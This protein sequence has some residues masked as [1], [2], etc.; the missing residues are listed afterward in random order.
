MSDTWV[1]SDIHMG[2][3]AKDGL[4]DFRTDASLIS[5]VGGL[6]R[7]D[8]LV[9]NGDIIDFAQAPPLV[10]RPNLASIPDNLLWTSDVSVAKLAT[11]VGAHG[12][13][14]EAFGRHVSDN[15]G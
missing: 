10:D 13:V 3:G 8:T 15:S 5:F 14:F 9:L 4:E 12:D 11:V 6:G 2:G 7:G 1:I